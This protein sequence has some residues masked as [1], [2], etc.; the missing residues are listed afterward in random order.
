MP[1][2]WIMVIVLSVLLSLPAFADSNPANRQTLFNNATD[3]LSTVG[4][5]P[6]IKKAMIKKR[7]N[8]RRQ[9][10]L[11]AAQDRKNAERH[12]YRKQ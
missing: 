6:E 12:K 2:R 1:Q 9:A 7:R 5:P 4:K 11:K 3:F 10:R 8:L